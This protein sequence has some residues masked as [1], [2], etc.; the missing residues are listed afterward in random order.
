MKFR[1]LIL[2]VLLILGA[3]AMIESFQKDNEIALSDLLYSMTDPFTSI[4]LTKPYT[5]GAS[6]NTWVVDDVE[7]IN[8]LLSF[9]EHYNVRKLKPEEIDIDD[10]IDQFSIDLIDHAG[11]T[12][13][14]LVNEDLIIQN[15]LL[16]YQIVDGPLDVDW[17]VQFFIHN[18]I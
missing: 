18:Q 3:Q 15:S 6:S 2:T 14:I 7:E 1:G 8:E 13:S 11:N 9:L 12:V 5:E 17:L 10:D 16:Y 4:L